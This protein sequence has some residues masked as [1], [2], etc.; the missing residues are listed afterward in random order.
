MITQFHFHERYGKYAMINSRSIGRIIQLI[1]FAKEAFTDDYTVFDVYKKVCFTRL[2]CT[3]ICA[4][5]KQINL[6]T[7]AYCIIMTTAVVGIDNFY[8]VMIHEVLYLNTQKP[9]RAGHLNKNK[10]KQRLIFTSFILMQTN[11]NIYNK[12]T[13]IEQALIMYESQYL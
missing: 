4:A 7:R 12:K 13:A 6:I 5:C 11:M 2:S 1:S 10:P 3:W 9:L 8:I